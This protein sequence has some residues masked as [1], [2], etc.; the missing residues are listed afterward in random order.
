MGVQSVL[1]CLGMIPGCRRGGKAELQSLLPFH[2]GKSP[3]QS[4][5]QPRQD[6]I[7]FPSSPHWSISPSSLY[8]PGY[9][10]NAQECGMEGGDAAAAVGV[11]RCS[12]TSPGLSCQDLAQ[13]QELLAAG[14]ALMGTAP[15]HCIQISPEKR[16]RRAQELLFKG[17]Q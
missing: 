8:S 15:L 10:G 7:E 1:S 16:S 17:M 13:F 11:T 2:L 9:H 6:G 3:F 12:R 4:H 5:S 14:F